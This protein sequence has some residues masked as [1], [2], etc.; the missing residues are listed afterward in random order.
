[1]THY[2]TGEGGR[3]AMVSPDGRDVF[4]PLSVQMLGP[5]LQLIQLVLDLFGS[6]SFSTLLSHSLEED[7]SQVHLSC[8]RIHMVRRT[9][10]C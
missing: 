7:T 10:K 6:V 5:L 4:G 9:M 2:K 8:N 3:Q 1:M